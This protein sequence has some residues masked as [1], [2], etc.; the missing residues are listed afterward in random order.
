[1]TIAVTGASGQLGRLVI[2]NL[3]ADAGVGDII[4]LARNPSKIADLGVTARAFDYDVADQLASALEG[5]HTL[6]LI[7]ASE[8][9]RRVPQHVAVI[10]AAKAASVEHI[11]YTSLL[12]AD[13]STIALAPEHVA[14]EE[15]LKASGVAHTVLRNG[16]YTENYTMGLGA[17]FEH[18]T[19][20][21]AAADGKI[22]SAT[23][24]DYA[25]AAAKV[26]RDPALQGTTHELAGDSSYTLADLAAAA[27]ALTGDTIRYVN[28]PMPDLAVA[29]TQAGMP[30]DFAM[31]PAATDVEVSKGALFD[32]SGILGKIIGRP[33]TPLDVAVAQALS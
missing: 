12:K 21:G 29:Y 11:V 7:S 19:L 3:K 9:G 27:S 20:I 18:K 16:W 32:D 4:A 25:L 26:L 24:E 28:L 22:S 23:R 33:T 8:I 15:A 13:T 1:M 17:A 31:F 14:T 2:E 10:E 6:L 5:V 30:E